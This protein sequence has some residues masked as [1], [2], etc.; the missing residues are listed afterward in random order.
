M[1]GPDWWQALTPLGKTVYLLLWAA[2]IGLFVVW[3]LS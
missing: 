1:R 2:A 3:G